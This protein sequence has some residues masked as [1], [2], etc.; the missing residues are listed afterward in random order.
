MTCSYIILFVYLFSLCSTP[1][2]SCSTGE[3][4]EEDFVCMEISLVGL[5]GNAQTVELFDAWASVNCWDAVFFFFFCEQYFTQA[6]GEEQRGTS[7]V[8]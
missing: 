1:L 8:I 2:Y 5:L 4:S 6:K 3:R 7:R